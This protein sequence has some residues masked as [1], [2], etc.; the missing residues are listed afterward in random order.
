MQEIFENV[1][2]DSA[3]TYSWNDLNEVDF[4][5]LVFNNLRI[6]MANNYFNY[7]YFILSSHDSNIKPISINDPFERKVLFYFSDEKSI[8]P[9]ALMDNYFAI[10]KCYLPFELE[11]SNV[12]PF[13]IAYVSN[14]PTFPAKEISQRN[15]DVFFSGNL[16][17]NRLELYKALHPIYK[18]CPLDILKIVIRLRHLHFI[19]WL[20]PLDISKYYPGW[21]INFTP[22][23]SKGMTKRAYAENLSDSRISLCPKG[24]SSPETFR[25]LE[26][27]RAGAII[28]SEKLP[29][30]HFYRGSPIITLDSWSEAPQIIKDLLDNPERLKILQEKTLNWWSNV[31]SENATALYIESKLKQLRSKSLIDNNDYS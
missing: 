16:N 1:F 24:F 6:N 8:F 31:C 9:K 18:Y 5:T 10:F 14:L 29:D 13:N 26:S 3:S 11:G 12:F 2:L 17:I 4:L 7:K 23:F 19:K 20:L 22:G 25:H 30:T 21:I 28:I 15:I 27:M